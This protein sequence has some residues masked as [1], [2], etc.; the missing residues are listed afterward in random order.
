MRET[1][2]DDIDCWMI[3]TDHDGLSFIARLT[4]FPNGVRNRAGLQAAM[5]SLAKD[6]DPDA[7]ANLTSLQSQPFDIPPDNRPIAVKAITRTGAEM[8]TVIL[9]EDWLAST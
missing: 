7:E 8:N 4:Y 1:T 5:R 6:L 3:D 9:P 2:V